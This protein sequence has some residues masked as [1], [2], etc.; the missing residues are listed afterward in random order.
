MRAIRAL[1]K[2][3]KQ[4]A[5]IADLHLALDQ[6]DFGDPITSQEWDDKHFGDG[7]SIAVR[8]L[9]S[10]FDIAADQSGVVDDATAE[11]INKRLFE[12][13]VFR[14]VE[15]RVTN[16]D[17]SSV[18]G[19]LLYAY[20]KDNVGGAYLGS[21][22]TNADGF[23]QIF[24]DRSMYAQAGEGVLEVK[25]IIDLIVQVYDAAGITLAE[26]EPIH[27]PSH[28]ESVDLGVPSVEIKSYRV[29]GKVASR[30]SA[31]IGDLRVEVVDKGVGPDVVLAPRATTNEDGAYQ[32]T[33]S[34]SAVRQR[35][36]ILPDLQA[37]VFVGDA[38]LGAS[39]V[40]FDA[41]QDEK[42]LDV[43]LDD[44]A[45]S[46]LRSE[47]EVLTDALASQLPGGLELGQLQ[48][49]DEQQDITYLANKTGWDARAVALAAQADQFSASTGGADDAPAIPQEFFYALF[50]AGLPANEE[51]LYH[52]DAKTLEG[53]WKTAAKQGVI[54]KDSADQIPNLIGRFQEQSAQKLRTSQAFA[55]PS[56]LDETLAVSGLDKAKREKFAQLYAANRTDMATF[57][58]SV[59]D[60][61]TFGATSE[62][63]EET[64]SRLQVDGKLG[65][66]TINNAPL[67]KKV[68]AKAGDN[69]LSDPLQL[70]QMGYHSEEAWTQ[71]LA[72]DDDVSIPVPEEIP[73]DK[74]ETR[75]A[76]YASYLAA[77]IRLSYP[78]AAVAQMV[79]SDAELQLTDAANFLTEHQGKFEIG[80]QPVEQYVAQNNLQLADDDER[81]V[82]VNRLQ[83]AYQITPSDRALTGL[84]KRGVDSAHDVLR[85]DK[86]TFVQSFAGDLGGAEDA[87]LTYDR[88]MQI[89]NVVLN[90]ALGYLNARTAPAIGVHSPPSVIDP[91]PANASDVI[92]YPTLETL[93][94][95]MDFCECEHCRSILSPAAY[96]VDLLL[97]LQSDDEVWTASLQSWKEKHDGAPYPFVDQ[98]AWQ[99]F[100]IEWNERH[101]GQSLPNTEIS[102]FDVLMS[103]RPDIE[104]L[105]LTCE[106]TNTALPYIDVVNETLEYFVAN[107]AANAAQDPSKSP[108]DGFT[109]HDS[110]D[111]ASE[112]L[113]A[114]PQFVIDSA[115]TTLRNEHFPAPLPFHQPL[116][117]L[118]RYFD[119]FE[120]P[121]PLAMER[122]RKN[123][124][125]D[126]DQTTNPPPPPTDY[127]WRDI[128]MEEI[129]LSRDEHKIL[130]NS[131]AVPLWNMYGFPTGTNDD[132]VIAELSNAKQFARRVGISYEDLVS[133]LKTRFIN[134]DSSVIP[135]VERLGVDFAMLAELKTKNDAP[136][137]AWFDTLLA[138][139][140]V[141][142]DPAEYGDNPNAPEDDYAPI[143]TWVKNVDNYDRI[144]GLITLT[145]AADTWAASTVYA[146][147]DCVWPT[148]AQPDSTTYYE[149]TAPGTSAATEPTSWPTTPGESWPDGDDV[150]WTC[151]DTSSSFSFDDLA[152]RYAD[153]AKIT[154]DIGAAE[155]VRM[156]RFVRLWKK[157]GWTIEQ[158]DAAI[159][160]LFRADLAPLEKSHVDTVAELDVGFLNLL[161]R[162][163]VL[164]GAMKALN[165]TPNRDLLPLL[166]CF[167]PIDTQ[168]ATSLYRQMFLNPS[169]LEQD[170]AF[171]DNG[172]GEFLGDN[173]KKPPEKLLVHSEA[174][175]SAFNLTSSELDL[176]VDALGLNT[177]VDVPYTHPQPSLEQAILDAGPGISYDNQ[178]KRLSYTGLLSTTTFDALRSVLGV[179]AEF[180]SAVDALHLANQTAL[181]PLTLMNVSEIF[182]RGW[183]ARK[184]KVSVRELLL[185]IQLTGLDPFVMSDPTNPAILRLISL[186]QALNAGA[187]ESD[188]ALYLIWNQDLSGK[189]APDPAQITELGRT[190]R[191]ISPASKISS[192][193]LRI[194]AAT[195]PARARHWFTARK[196]ATLSS[197]S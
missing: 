171:A 112:D 178:Q 115:Y 107:A 87:A 184:L 78:T 92:A 120:V 84:M 181:E 25:E 6:L 132:D 42:A 37:R 62:E 108:L 150:R 7:T 183:L 155:F 105:P 50:R 193:W 137:D 57:W 140:A 34:D 182:R 160:A 139:L 131:N 93:F 48:E 153:P 63:R 18:V 14:L 135:K 71:L 94:D 133:V 35:G 186:V 26:S 8:R 103:R 174:L 91:A 1:L 28:E 106:N 23:Y 3:G 145:I 118:R 51:V 117:R 129:G 70:A 76:N 89:H 20:D 49:T 10:H 188:A 24:Y 66:L 161:P 86:D 81:V 73:G 146:V 122:L 180:Q 38:L 99:E 179:T 142:P 165:L 113:L 43:L 54:P 58:Q 176:I 114:S 130:S 72:E 149:C 123:D 147:G 12:L 40:R 194:P 121:L 59:G 138:N 151:R 127:G 143:R 82:Q 36:K 104:H 191:A 39:E 53:V 19:N 148:T 119:K 69:V 190:L 85:Y 13:D 172:Y 90:V 31:S 185:L 109:G 116:E 79:G 46:A 158:T 157:L 65:F 56:L 189:S 196:S 168:G 11:R 170:A 74:P 2:P 128:L 159:C 80:V 110:E 68:H 27:K 95:S 162:L 29:E 192:S 169:L 32:V 98:V 126:V 101:P 175:R 173:I 102:P 163:G 41:S 125:L 136:T 4:G 30:V 77:Q 111:V 154:K 144:M 164:K 177:V 134:P 52:T 22:N 61:P 21:A 141:P 167:V 100:Q 166:A 45:S 15:G 33:F 55:G 97:F 197:L 83:R 47:H 187:L 67:I 5:E 17:G 195:L 124:V 88:S 75:R 60:D 64:V 9:Q 16:P 96:L 44:R 156:L 152:F